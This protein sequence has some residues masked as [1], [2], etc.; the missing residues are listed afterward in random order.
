MMQIVK[1]IEALE[2]RRFNRQRKIVDPRPVASHSLPT[3]LPKSKKPLPPI[4]KWRNAV[5]G[6]MGPPSPTTR[7]VLL[8]LSHHMNQQGG[9]CFPSQRLLARET[10]LSLR[11]VCRH[12]QI[13]AAEKWILIT[14]GMGYAKGWRKFEYQ[15]AVPTF[16]SDLQ[17]ALLRNIADDDHSSLDGDDSEIYRGDSKSTS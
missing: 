12:I 9:S 1:K 2:K 14:I 4:I 10:R 8:A 15:A 16:T 5:L 3:E 11:A 17:S 7:L 13:A 6:K